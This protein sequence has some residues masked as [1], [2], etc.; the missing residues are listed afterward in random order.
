M[1]TLDVVVYIMGGIIAILTGSA[2][3]TQWRRTTANDVKATARDEEIGTLQNLVDTL[4]N[5]VRTLETNA[6]TLEQLTINQAIKIEAL[7][8]SLADANTK[9]AVLAERVNVLERSELAK[10]A[11]IAKLRAE[12]LLVYQERDKLT[13]EVNTL[14]TELKTTRDEMLIERGKNEAYRDTMTKFAEKLTVSSNGEKT[15]TGEVGVVVS[16]EPGEAG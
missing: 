6:G 8:T 3:V 10:D 15:A 13:T 12:M 7:E 16:S 2:S 5:K 4:Q 11:E 9:S 1:N 14:K